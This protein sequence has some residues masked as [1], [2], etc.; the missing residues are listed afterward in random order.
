MRFNGWRD[1]GDE[2]EDS[3]ITPIL[4]SL[5]RLA[6]RSPKI[7]R[8]ELHRTKIPNPQEDYKWLLI[9][10]AF[11]NLETLRFDSADILDDALEG[12]RGLKVLELRACDGVTGVGLMSFVEGRDKRFELILDSCPGVTQDDICALSEKAKVDMKQ[13]T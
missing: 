2:W 3:A 10:G 8:I 11:P 1:G 4:Q 6:G 9:D 7:K 5:R 12:A 13:E